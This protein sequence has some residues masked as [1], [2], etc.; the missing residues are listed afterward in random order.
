MAGLIFACLHFPV[1][2]SLPRGRVTLSGCAVVGGGVQI[3][4]GD[5]FVSVSTGIAP[6]VSLGLRGG[7]EI[8]IA[9]RLA[10]GLHAD[11]LF[12]TTPIL[13][14]VSDGGA[15]RTVWTAPPVSGVLSAMLLVYFR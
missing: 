2:Q 12:P 13:L 15:V 4:R 3:G 14:Q 7:A 5:G 9:R 8:P 6:Y 11:V 1:G 10:I